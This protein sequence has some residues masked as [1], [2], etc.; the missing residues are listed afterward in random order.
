MMSTHRIAAKIATAA[1]L[2][3][4]LAL[5]TDAKAYFGDERDCPSGT[6]S[7]PNNGVSLN[8]INPNGLTR[9][10]MKPQG[11]GLNGRE[12][13]TLKPQGRSTSGDVAETADL[14]ALQVRAIRLADGRT[15]LARQR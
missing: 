7:D 14:G 15:L 6:C 9:N 1:L 10:G 8:G 2:L 13:N 11:T 3:G 4:G 5:A 12:I